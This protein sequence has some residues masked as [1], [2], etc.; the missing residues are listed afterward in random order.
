MQASR[1]ALSAVA[2]S[3]ISF[4]QGSAERLQRST[5]CSVVKG[6]GAAAQAEPSAKP[7]ARIETAIGLRI[8]ASHPLRP[9]SA[10]EGRKTS[11]RTQGQVRAPSQ[12]A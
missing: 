9:A 10:S 8:L 4:R 7:H 2:I 11:L 3:A 12:P 6:A 1:V 5:A